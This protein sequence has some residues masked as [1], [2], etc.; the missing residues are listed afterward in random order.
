MHC[1]LSPKLRKLVLDETPPIA[2]GLMQG[3]LADMDAELEGLL[4]AYDVSIAQ[5]CVLIGAYNR[6]HTKETYDAKE[7]LRQGTTLMGG[8]EY[9]AKRAIFIYEFHDRVGDYFAYVAAKH[10]SDAPESLQQAR[11]RLG[12]YKDIQQYLVDQGGMG[13]QHARRLMD[14]GT[15]EICRL[16]DKELGRA[17]SVAR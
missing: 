6:S 2:E 7:L 11:E 16:V 8:D 4:E 13:N 10:A 14:S 17:P 5:L 12:L 9:A 1:A 3:K 15:S